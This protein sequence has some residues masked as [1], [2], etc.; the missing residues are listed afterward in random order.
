MG[1]RHFDDLSLN[2]GDGLNVVVGP[3]DAGRTAAISAL[4]VLLVASEESAGQNYRA[5]TR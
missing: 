3:N 2:F 4:R 5:A 1:F